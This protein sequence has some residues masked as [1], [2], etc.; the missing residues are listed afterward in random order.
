MRRHTLVLAGVFLLLLVSP[1]QTAATPTP[2]EN[3]Q[4]NT[5]IHNFNNDEDPK[6]I[7]IKKDFNNDGETDRIIIVD[8][9]NN[10]PKSVDLQE[11]LEY[12]GVQVIYDTGND[13][14][15]EIVVNFARQDGKWTHVAS[16]YDSENRS[17]Q[18]EISSNEAEIPDLTRI[19]PVITVKSAHPWTYQEN[20]SYDLQL[21][22]RPS[23][24]CS[25][26]EKNYNRQNNVTIRV[27]DRDD[28][29]QPEHEI[30]Q[31][32]PRLP[33][34]AA[35]MRTQIMVSK[36][37]ERTLGQ[38][39]GVLWPYIGTTADRNY[40]R[41][42]N[43]MYPPIQTNWDTGSVQEVSEF[44]ASR[45]EEDNYFVYSFKDLAKERIN[46]PSFEHPFS[47]YDLAGND[48]GIPE[49]QIRTVAFAKGGPF[50]LGLNPLRFRPFPFTQIRYSWDQNNDRKWDY[51]IGVAGTNAYSNTTRIGSYRLRM[52]GYRDLPAWVLSRQWP[53]TSFVHATDGFSSSEGIYTGGFSNKMRREI[54]DLEKQTSPIFNASHAPAGFRLEVNAQYNTEPRLYYSPIDGSLHLY[55]LD[56][57]FWNRTDGQAVVRYDN[58]DSDPF[59]DMWQL[60][61]G[62][63]EGTLV[64]E[65]DTLVYADSETISFKKTAVNQSAFVTQP[66]K[67]TR[68]W[69]QLR[70]QL[71]RTGA[72]TADLESIYRR[73]DGET[74]T[75]TDA[76]FTDYVATDDRFRIYATLSAESQTR[77]NTSLTLPAAKRVVFVFGEDEGTV[78]VS[79]ATPPS[80]VITNTTAGTQSITPL[81]ENEIQVTVQ[82]GGWLS[83]ENV[84]VAITDKDRTIANR[85]ISVVGKQTR[86]VKLRWWPTAAYTETEIKLRFDGETVA[87]QPLVETSERRDAPSLLTRYRISSRSVPLALGLGLVMV[88]GLVVTT[89][90]ILR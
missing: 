17:L 9:Q 11:A 89:R 86:T 13:G 45:E 44:V 27:V 8:R 40:I 69:R 22:C 18:Y 4:P 37:E 55:G 88:L 36:E 23:V 31:V 58:V 25:F 48:D 16:V 73:Y 24:R 57:G 81:E 60:R 20:V 80:L 10:L 19:H 71:N 59:V 52:P 66:P 77:G 1:V 63:Q 30:R 70:N 85:T 14:N 72:L 87:S 34:Y 38:N 35:V 61:D 67:T 62:A 49:L 84:T 43:R 15:A 32:E 53:G 12:D 54:L 28:D 47:F 5:N 51:K 78:D 79:R 46:D 68:E 21:T 50:R 75:V 26:D 33:S 29:G 6:I 7:S 83:A 42:Y 76:T 56:Y 3:L 64:A 90:R 39:D 41:P 82:N 74:V 2:S 65:N